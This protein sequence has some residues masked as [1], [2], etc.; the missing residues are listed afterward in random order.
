MSNQVQLMFGD[1][2]VEMKRMI[3]GSVDLAITSPP[4]NLNDG[5]WDMGGNGRRKRDGIEYLTHSDNM[6]QVDY[7]RWQIAVM[8]ELYRIAKPGASFFYNHKTRTLNGELIHPMLWLSKTEWTIR[9]EIVWDR[10]STH[11]HEPRLFWPVDERIYWMTKGK[12]ALNNVNVGLPSV[13]REFGPTPNTW[14]PAPFTLELPRMLLKA[15]NAQPGQIVLDPFMG[16]AT[17]GVAALE[18]GCRF[19][20]VEIAE[21]YFNRAAIR[22]NDT[23]RQIKRLPKQLTGNVTDFADMPLWAEVSA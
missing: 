7:E 21:D 1:C 9:Q 8:N 20:G 16:S 18:I 3:D 6:P 10:I 17:T 11:N 14:H 4:Y 5:T 2:L 22:L 23:E 13:W 12:P 19:V 15:I